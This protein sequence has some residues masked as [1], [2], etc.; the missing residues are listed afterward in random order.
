MLALALLATSSANDDGLEEQRAIGAQRF[1][2]KEQLSALRIKYRKDETTEALEEKLRKHTLEVAQSQTKKTKKKRD[3]KVAFE[4]GMLGL[5][6]TIDTDAS[7]FISQEEFIAQ[8]SLDIET[9]NPI[10]EELATKKFQEMDGNFDDVLSRVEAK[11]YIAATAQSLEAV[12]ASLKGG[13]KHTAEQLE[14]MPAA[15][16]SQRQL[17][18]AWAALKRGKRPARPNDDLPKQEL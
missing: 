14:A 9:G 4:I 13:W 17:A 10:S 1:K 3:P 12:E 11:K 8:S 7:G 6:D 2:L 15:E 18:A 16:K 5:F